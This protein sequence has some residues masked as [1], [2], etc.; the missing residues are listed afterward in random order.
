MAWL[1]GGAELPLELD[2]LEGGLGKVALIC[3]E[4]GAELG[5]WPACI[6]CCISLS[7]V[8]PDPDDKLLSDDNVLIVS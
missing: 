8:L 7:P 4:L 5:T 2:A 1:T 6:G 3:N